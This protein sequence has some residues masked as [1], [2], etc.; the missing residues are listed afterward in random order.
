MAIT[1]QWSVSQADYTVTENGAPQRVTT[2]HWRCTGTENEST[3]SAYGTVEVPEDDVAADPAF[4]TD[5]SVA[6]AAA[7]RLAGQETIEQSIAAQLETEARP[8]VASGRLWETPRGTRAWVAGQAYA[9]GDVVLFRGTPW[10]VRQ[11]HT[12]QRGWTPDAVPALWEIRTASTPTEGS[13]LPWLAGEAVAVGD[14]RR[15]QSV[16][17]EAVQA[18]TTQAGWTPTAVPALWREVV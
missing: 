15:F 6:V 14:R 8:T 7:Q 11:A 10:T 18:H 12:S 9:V 13:V 16:V 4:L 5:E 1:Y 2:L 3:G 17:Y